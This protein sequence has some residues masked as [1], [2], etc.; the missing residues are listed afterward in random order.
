MVTKSEKSSMSYAN[1]IL[2]F[3]LIGITLTS[4][5]W[6]YYNANTTLISYQD[7]DY[8]THKITSRGVAL[9]SLLPLG[10]FFNAFSLLLAYYRIC[11]RKH[12][13]IYK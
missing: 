5:G 11:K 9:S 7:E 2:I 13:I 8:V 10:I 12:S 1:A 4:V 3:A 6:Y